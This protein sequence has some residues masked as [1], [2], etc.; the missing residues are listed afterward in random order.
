[1]I[2]S[3]SRSRSARW[4]RSASV[5]QRRW[6][7]RTAICRTGCLARGRCMSMR[8]AGGPAVRAG[9]CGPRPP[10]R[11][12]SCRSPSI[13]TASSSTRSSAPPTPGSSSPIAGTAMSTLTPTSA[14]CAGRTSSATSAAT[15]R[16]CLAEWSSERPI[17][18]TALVCLFLP[19]QRPFSP[20]K[21][22][23]APR[24][25]ASCTWCATA[26]LGD[27]VGE[28]GT[29]PTGNGQERPR[30]TA[31]TAELPC[32]GRRFGGLDQRRGP[33]GAGLTRPEPRS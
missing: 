11:R 9:R 18:P 12:R 21:P 31:A 2:C 15:Q 3:A 5:P 25:L 17:G 22:Q 20:P 16:A 28:R 29:S 13:A 19:F 32:R 10:L 1:M 27:R 23:P 7:A 30:R 6:L 24:Q 26:D 14:R 4:T 33:G 8:P